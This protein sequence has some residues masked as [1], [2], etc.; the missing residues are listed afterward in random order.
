MVEALRFPYGLA[1]GDGE[2][3]IADT[4]HHVVRALRGIR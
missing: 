4:R 1:A 2:L 3:L